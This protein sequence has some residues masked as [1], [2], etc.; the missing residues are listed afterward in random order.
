LIDPD[1]KENDDDLPKLDR[2]N[3]E[4]G[5]DMLIDRQKRERPHDC[6]ERMENAC[7]DTDGLVL[8]CQAL[9]EKPCGSGPMRLLG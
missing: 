7:R 4:L 1:R 8:R 5:S 2:R 9:S 3:R 6:S